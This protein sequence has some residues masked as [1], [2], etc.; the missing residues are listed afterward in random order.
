MAMSLIGFILFGVLTLRS[1]KKPSGGGLESV[2]DAGAMASK[3][4]EAGPAASAL[5][6]SVLFMI[7]G[8][9]IGL[10]LDGLKINPF[11]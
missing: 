8:T 10:A 4:K 2:P 7:I 3:F 5:A 1:A 6:C 11:W 9:A